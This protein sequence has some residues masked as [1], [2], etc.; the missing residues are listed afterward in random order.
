M[1]IIKT[2]LYLY[3]DERK[4]LC[5][6]IKDAALITG[7]SRY[8]KVSLFQDKYR[9]FDYICF[10]LSNISSC[11][12]VLDFISVNMEWLMKKKIV[13]I[14]NFNKHLNIDSYVNKI[15]AL[16]MDNIKYENAFYFGEDKYKNRKLKNKFI[17]FAAKIRDIMELDIKRYPDELL[18][19]DIEAF[20]NEHNMCTLCTGSMDMVIGTPIEYMY[21]CGSIYIVTEGGR[22]FINILRN[23]EVSAAVYNEY[24][25]FAKLKGLQLRGKAEIISVE[26]PEYDRVLQMKK[27]KPENVKNL[28]MIM[29]VLKI[30][31]ERADFLCSEIKV[32]GYD[33]KQIYEW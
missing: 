18:K 10:V 25:G 14:Y 24:E 21:E 19:N 20:L 26:N 4:E 1:G 33:A 27:L 6:S 13:L 17:E 8:C 15:K 30:K 2:I 32:K 22:K 16:L 12:R 9:E 11:K 23:E 29:N 31:L 5:T 3:E 28:N 7:P